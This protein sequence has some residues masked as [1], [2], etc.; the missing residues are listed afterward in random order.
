[1]GVLF[2]G[3]RRQWKRTDIESQETGYLKSMYATAELES[4][5]REVTAVLRSKL[6]P[7]VFSAV[8]AD[9]LANMVIA[10]ALADHKQGGKPWL[11]YL[12]TR[13]KMA[14]TKA[15]R[16]FNAKRRP[17]LDFRGTAS[18]LEAGPPQVAG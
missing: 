16:Y 10:G 7:R 4:D 12:I 5:H 3:L 1:M 9:S 18:E 15:N 13:A 2:W 14:A 11:A 17:D 6:S 8:D